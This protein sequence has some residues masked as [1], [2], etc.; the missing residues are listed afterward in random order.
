MNILVV[1]YQRYNGRCIIET[2]YNVTEWKP[3]VFQQ[4]NGDLLIAWR[5][6]VYDPEAR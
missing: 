2:F 5:F 6:Y 3:D 1:Y 4:M